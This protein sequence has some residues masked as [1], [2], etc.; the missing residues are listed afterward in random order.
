MGLISGYRQTVFN[1][2]IFP[3]ESFFFFFGLFGAT[4]MAYGNSQ[5]RGQIGAV[6]AGLHHSHSNAGSVSHLQP[7][8]Q[9]RTTLGH[10]LTEQCQGLNPSS[11][12]Y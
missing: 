7:I 3:F 11:H 4:P 8:P 12:G 9:L 10:E 2:V 6:A 5:A 1:S